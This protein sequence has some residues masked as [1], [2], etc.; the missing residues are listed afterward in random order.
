M[1]IKEQRL[2]LSEKAVKI[3]FRFT[4]HMFDVHFQRDISQHTE[5]QINWVQ[6]CFMEAEAD[7]RGTSN[8]E[9]F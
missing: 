6:M 1:N 8:V 5:S 4:L 2:Q 7:V 3:L 9:H